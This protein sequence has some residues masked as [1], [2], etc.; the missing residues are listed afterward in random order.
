MRMAGVQRIMPGMAPHFTLPEKITAGMGWYFS[1]RG[2]FFTMCAFLIF[3]PV[4]KTAISYWF[5]HQVAMTLEE[6]AKLKTKAPVELE[7]SV[8]FEHA[9]KVINTKHD[10]FLMPIAGSDGEVFYLRK[11]SYFEGEGKDGPIQVKGY[12]GK[13]EQIW[14]WDI[15]G[16]RSDDEKVWADAGLEISREAEIIYDDDWN[17]SKFGAVLSAIF[18]VISMI[19]MWVFIRRVM[20]TIGL[21]RDPAALAKALNER[22]GFDG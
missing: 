22:L 14:G 12:A 21:L 17:K 16:I 7:I 1:L 9:V 3:Y 6:I 13:W 15:Y 18:A 19:M 11:D 4:G 20:R 5:P 8:D 10:Y 2:L